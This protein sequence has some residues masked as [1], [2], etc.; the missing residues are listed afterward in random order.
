MTCS[1]G[2]VDASE[3]SVRIDLTEGTLSSSFSSDELDPSELGSGCGW[4]LTLA[5]G[6]GSCFPLL[7]DP[8]LLFFSLANSILLFISRSSSSRP[9][10][11]SS[12]LGSHSSEELDRVDSGN[13]LSFSSL[14]LASSSLSSAFFRRTIF[15]SSA[16]RTKP[17]FSRILC[18]SPPRGSF[19]MVLF[20]SSLRTPWLGVRTASSSSSASTSCPLSSDSPSSS[21][22]FWS[23]LSTGSWR[24]DLLELDGVL[25]VGSFLAPC[26]WIPK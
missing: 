5:F 11:S 17:Y 9:G 21:S 13:C 25:S 1:G 16:S 23:T 19:P 14:R 8:L 7:W 3:S 15:G 6:V 12:E 10:N 20:S 26:I 2:I 4:K 18:R 24:G 22:R